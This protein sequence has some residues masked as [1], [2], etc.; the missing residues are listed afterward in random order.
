M[1]ASIA[2]GGVEVDHSPW[3]YGESKTQYIAI[4]NDRNGSLTVFSLGLEDNTP[5]Y[6]QQLPNGTWST[7]WIPLGGESKQIAVGNDSNG[8]LVAFSIGVADN[9]PY[10]KQQLPNGTW[11][12]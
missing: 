8:S 5:Y 9:A 2:Y 7:E 1:L 6:K 10:Y 12:Y 11:R 3:K 4:G